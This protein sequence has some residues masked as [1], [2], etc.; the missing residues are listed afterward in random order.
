MIKLSREV[1]V[2]FKDEPEKPTK[3]NDD[4]STAG[5]LNAARL[6]IAY[7]VVLLMRRIMEDFTL[8][9]RFSVT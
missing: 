3:R 9:N 4:R 2:V 6:V 8:L 1:M 7:R 5:T